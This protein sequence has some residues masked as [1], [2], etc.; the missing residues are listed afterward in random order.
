MQGSWYLVF[1]LI[2]A[3]V[4]AVGAYFM[5]AAQLRGINS[6]QVTFWTTLVTAGAFMAVHYPW[7]DRPWLEPASWWHVSALAV[8]FYIG[9]A[10]TVIALDKGAVSLATPMLGTKVVMVAVI[11]ALLAGGAVSSGAWVAAVMS[12]AGVILL[13]GSSDRRAGGE[14]GGGLT[15]R[16]V[17]I[18]L[19]ISFVAALAFSAYDVGIKQWSPASGFG[20]L[21][22]PAIVLALVLCVTLPPVTGERVFVWPKAGRVWLALTAAFFAGQALV[23]MWSLGTFGDPTGINV[24]YGSRGV[25]SV[26]LV[27][28][29][30]L[31]ST[32]V[33][34]F[35]SR[36][37]FLRRLGGS[38][39]ISGAIGV[40]VIWG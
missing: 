9:L 2:A 11:D 33:E 10:A 5:K 4:Y 38:L 19:G 14:G 22:P 29:V 36:G 25:W 7:A 1:P 35:H 23:L 8:T 26:V 20:R 32:S 15:R 34:T 24:V 37:V 30:G 39:A 40:L 3:V 6:A 13:A 18:G 16:A 12:M 21:V 31:F 17:W 27:A 28:I